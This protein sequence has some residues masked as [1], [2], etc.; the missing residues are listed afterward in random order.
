MEKM[1]ARIN[2]II[3]QIGDMKATISQLKS[4][5]DSLKSKITQLEKE[6]TELTSNHSGMS[7]EAANDLKAGID[8]QVQELDA[9]IDMLKTL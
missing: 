1:E 2:D 7:A 8:K 3:S 6:K 5:R 9:C 4:E